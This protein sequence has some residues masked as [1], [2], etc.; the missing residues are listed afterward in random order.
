MPFRILLQKN[1]HSSVFKDVKSTLETFLFCISDFFKE[2][3][4]LRKEC[5][6]QSQ[7]QYTMAK[8]TLLSWE[9]TCCFAYD[10]YAQTRRNSI[11]FFNMF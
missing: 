5:I 4:W 6:I 2:L 8:I 11:Y 3:R 1:I 9:I 10:C 7:A